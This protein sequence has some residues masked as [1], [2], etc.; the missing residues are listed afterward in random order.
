MP[1]YLFVFGR[2]PRLSYLELASFFPKAQLLSPEVASVN[3]E[4]T[5][6]DPSELVSLLGGTVKIA[7]VLGTIGTPTA[8]ELAEFIQRE[9]YASQLTFTVGSLSP[10]ILIKTDLLQ[11]IKKIFQNQGVAA[12]F[13]EPKDGGQVSSVVIQKQ[14]VVELLLLN[15]NSKVLVART[16]AVQDFESWARRDR[17]RPYADPKSGML[18]PKVARMIVNIARPAG[19]SPNSNILFDPFCGM[20]TVLAEA[21]LT[22]WQVVGSD[23]SNESVEKARANLMWLSDAYEIDKSKMQLFTSDAT[24]ITE[25]LTA[26]VD[27]IATEPFMGPTSLGDKRSRATAE[28]IRNVL[29]GLEKLYIGCLKEWAGVLEPG[30]KLVIAFPKIVFGARE[31]AVKKVIDNCENLGYTTLTGPIEYS[32]P[33]AVVKRMI[34][35]FEKI[36]TRLLNMTNT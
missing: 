2:T 9:N 13:V 21:L 27:A 34:Y 16:L 26:K 7:M 14:G 31:Q 3:Q 1:T 23:Q 36:D 8:V 35:V 11:E 10:N 32:R 17:D 15:Q 5:P 19:K 30:G 4:N 18:P 29:R 28:Q 33:Q 22:G 6:I 12:R 20:G 24:H 25:K